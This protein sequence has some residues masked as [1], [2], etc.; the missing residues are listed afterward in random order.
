MTTNAERF[1]KSPLA[2][3]RD[4]R[5]VRHPEAGMILQE[6]AGGNEPRR[7]AE[8][9]RLGSGDAMPALLA[10]RVSGMD[11]RPRRPEEHAPVSGH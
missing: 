5:Q 3:V 7:P 11:R 9:A 10:P 8:P 4:A 6:C 2:G 1:M